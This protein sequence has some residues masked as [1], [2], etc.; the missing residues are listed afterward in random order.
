MRKYY[1][2]VKRGLY[3]V[4][5]CVS[6]GQGIIAKAAS[7][8][9]INSSTPKISEQ[10]VQSVTSSVEVK[11]HGLNVSKTSSVVVSKVSGVTRSETVNKRRESDLNVKS[12]LKTDAE[13]PAQ[14]EKSNFWLSKNVSK[15][16]SVSSSPNFVLN[17][18]Q[19]RIAKINSGKCAKKSIHHKRQTKKSTPFRW[20]TASEQIG[21]PLLAFF[22][23]SL[24][25]ICRQYGT[26]SRSEK[27]NG[28]G[29]VKMLIEST[30]QTAKESREVESMI[31]RTEVNTRQI[32][33]KI[34]LMNAV[35]VLMKTVEKKRKR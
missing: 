12:E 17:N 25:W 9:P 5:F 2:L 32:A 7:I 14:Y 31:P 15:V 16:L 35:C 21:L 23:S 24:I 4:L 28:D 20:L 11:Q 18:R 26:V 22:M 6:L 34:I 27:P 10:S 1:T 3:C 19:R 29:D 30:T 8:K 13:Q 33:E